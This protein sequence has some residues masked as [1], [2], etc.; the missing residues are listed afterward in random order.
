MTRKNESPPARNS[1]PSKHSKVTKSQKEKGSERNSG[2]VGKRSDTGRT[3]CELD[4]TASK[5][6]HH[7]LPGCLR[8]QFR[9][10]SDLDVICPVC[11]LDIHKALVL[12]ILDVVSGGAPSGKVVRLV[13]SG[14]SNKQKRQKKSQQRSES[15]RQGERCE[16][17]LCDE[18]SRSSHGKARAIQCRVQC[19]VD[20]RAKP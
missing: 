6:F 9:P 7:S 13:D 11:S 8:L 5:L 14:H 1:A 16:K 17:G 18:H 2:R 19:C 3:T 4:V 15:N 12:K 20:R 10:G